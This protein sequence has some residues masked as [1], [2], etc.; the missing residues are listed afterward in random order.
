MSNDSD[1]QAFACSQSDRIA[2]VGLTK[3]PGF[4][5]LTRMMDA[6][7][8]RAYTKVIQC[9]PTEEAKVCALQKEARAASAFCT[10]L[11]KAIEWHVRC[12]NVVQPDKAA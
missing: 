9:D 8:Q 4:Q 6:A 12:E 5:V 1:V 10:L 11:R 7:C 3:H 2:L